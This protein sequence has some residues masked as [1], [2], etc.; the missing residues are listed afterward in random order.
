MIWRGYRMKAKQDPKCHWRVMLIK[1]DPRTSSRPSEA[2][3]VGSGRNTYLHLKRKREFVD[4][5]VVVFSGRARLLALADA[6]YEAI[7]G[8]ATER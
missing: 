5:E 2:R 8:E 3:V 6:I 7:E 4:D 1:E